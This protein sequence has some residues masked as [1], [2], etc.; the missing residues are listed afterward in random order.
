MFCAGCQPLPACVGLLFSD[1]PQIPDSKG[2][3]PAIKVSK[4]HSEAERT[5]RWGWACQV[6]A[7][8]A[9]LSLDEEPPQYSEKVQH[10]QEATPAPLPRPSLE[11][12]TASQKTA[13][14]LSSQGYETD[15]SN[16]SEAT[17]APLW[18]L[19]M[20]T[21]DEL[22]DYAAEAEPDKTPRYFPEQP[23]VE[24]PVEVIDLR[25]PE[26]LVRYYPDMPLV[27]SPVQDASLG[28]SSTMMSWESLDSVYS[29]ETLCSTSASAG[30]AARKSMLLSGRLTKLRRIAALSNLREAL[31]HRRRSPKPS[32]I[33][34][35]TLSK[36]SWCKSPHK[37]AGLLQ[38]KRR[39]AFRQLQRPAL[40]RRRDAIWRTPSTRDFS[41]LFPRKGSSTFG[42]FS[43]SASYVPSQITTTLYCHSNDGATADDELEAP[44]SLHQH[45][46]SSGRPSRSSSYTASQNIFQMPHSHFNDGLV[47]GNEFRNAQDLTR[48]DT[49]GIF[50]RSNSYIDSQRVFRTSYC[51]SDDGHT[52]DDEMGSSPVQCK[53]TGPIS[54]HKDSSWVT[55]AVDWLT[56]SWQGCRAAAA[57]ATYH[58]GLMALRSATAMLRLWL[59]S[60][61]PLTAWFGFRAIDLISGML[62]LDSAF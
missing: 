43:R 4:T 47:A 19:S 15:I 52:A 3:R 41:T 31:G 27:Q 50:S 21:D 37:A 28:R 26:H 20:E 39:N 60:A 29:Q 5:T 18:S 42:L 34:H 61:G 25:Q 10:N 49:F 13:D 45:F 58:F 51:R 36:A 9:S 11:I 24:S 8:L 44:I 62:Y 38:R 32:V 53:S 30:G 46:K 16:T 33:K 35:S 40:P 1:F 2:S 22:E 48:R 6:L 57:D 7:W 54:L 12:S 56:S 23:I 14:E 59:L 17:A 55:T